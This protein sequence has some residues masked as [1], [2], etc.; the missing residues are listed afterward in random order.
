MTIDYETWQPPPE[1]V[2]LDWESDVLRPTERLL[3]IADA[4]GTPL[5][6]FAEMGEYLWLERDRPVIAEQ[7]AQQWRD[8]V[9]RGHDVQLHLHPTWLP[10]MNPSEIDGRWEW[11]TTRT[12]ADDYPGDLSAAIERC[13]SA[14]ETVIR[15]LAPD[16]KVVAFRAGT[17]EAQ[18]FQRLHDA[19]AENGILVRLVGGAG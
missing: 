13:K 6:I 11:D 19:L 12:R 17:Y 15:P 5:T 9:A 10:E 16:Y 14:L 7:M 4:T 18:P 3:E 1:G 8:A 2:V